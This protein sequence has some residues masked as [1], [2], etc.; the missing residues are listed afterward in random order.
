V[1]RAL[2][3]LERWNDDTDMGDLAELASLARGRSGAP[4]GGLVERDAARSGLRALR[5]LLR[6]AHEARRRVGSDRDSSIIICFFADLALR[7][8]HP[9][10]VLPDYDAVIFDEAHRL[11]DIATE[12]FGLRVSETRLERALGDATFPRLRRRR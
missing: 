6:H 12:F 2:S 8:P 10:R 1:A 4:R 3:A 11:E 5:R 7:G 9:G